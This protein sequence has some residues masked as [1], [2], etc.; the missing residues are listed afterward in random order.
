MAAPTWASLGAIQQFIRSK[1]SWILN[2]T[3]IARE[4]QQFI[5]QKKFDEGG[6]FLFLG[7]KYPINL[8]KGS[9]LQSSISFNDS[10]WQVYLG[11]GI[12]QERRQSEVRKLMVQWYREQAIE[13]L[14]G[15]VYH[16]ARIMG[17]QPPEIFIRSQKSRWGSCHYHQRKIY[18]NWQLIMTPLNVI[19][20]VV[21]HELSHLKVPDH[22][23]RFW[24]NVEK[25]L[26]DYKIRR[27]WLK[28][29]DRDI[30]LP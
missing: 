10:A 29:N 27:R 17:L 14:G 30:V 6:I 23:K 13:L 20:Y 7:K 8:T 26:T 5:A 24:K 9:R 21:V 11:A 2:K 3:R 18:L 15:R 12:S 28:D 25:F 22:S 4:D 16:Y 1:S 19:D